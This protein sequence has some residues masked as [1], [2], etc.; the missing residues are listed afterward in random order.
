LPFSNSIDECVKMSGDLN[1]NEPR[2][3]FWSNDST[4]D[5][6][7]SNE[8]PGNIIVLDVKKK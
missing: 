2:N 3:R 5:S 8:E 7:H 1:S 6:Y 4:Q